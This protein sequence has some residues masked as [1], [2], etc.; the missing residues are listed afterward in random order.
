M[1]SVHLID[2]E[3]GVGFINRVSLI[4]RIGCSLVNRIKLRTLEHM[5]TE[6]STCKISTVLCSISR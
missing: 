2:V 1:H 6:I 4:N 5:I 3:I